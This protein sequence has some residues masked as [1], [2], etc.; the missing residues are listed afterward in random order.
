MWEY[1]VSIIYINIIKNLNHFL[2]TCIWKKRE[3]ITS[4]ALFFYKSS[5]HLLLIFYHI[6]DTNRKQ[7][8]VDTGP[9]ILQKWQK[10]TRESPRARCPRMPTLFRPAGKST[11][12][13]ALRYQSAF[14]N[15]PKDAPEDGRFDLCYI[16]QEYNER[17]SRW[18]NVL[19]FVA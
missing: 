4:T 11:R 12:R 18:L 16:S 6:L 8:L 13:R 7:N 15:S 2:L 5:V 9:P 14:P 10:G 19:L 3:D 17:F 1:L